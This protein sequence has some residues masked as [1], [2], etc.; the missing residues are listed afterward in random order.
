MRY[1]LPD[2]FFYVHGDKWPEFRWCSAGNGN[3]VTRFC[4]SQEIRPHFETHPFCVYVGLKGWYKNE[5]LIREKKK[6]FSRVAIISVIK[7]DA[8]YNTNKIRLNICACCTYRR[9]LI[10]VRVL[11]NTPA[12]TGDT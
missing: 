8:M 10:F 4:C 1:Q 9:M 2:E 11:T 7:Y 12:A 6:H 3:H 5:S